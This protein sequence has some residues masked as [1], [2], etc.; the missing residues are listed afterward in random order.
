MLGGNEGSGGTGRPKS[1]RSAASIVPTGSAPGAGG[2]AVHAVQCRG[3][4]T[5][6]WKSWCRL[7]LARSTAA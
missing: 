1:T 6:H 3:D 2:L 5:W 4:F 7:G